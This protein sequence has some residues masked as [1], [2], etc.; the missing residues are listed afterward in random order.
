MFYL[1]NA[2]GVHFSAA[3][4]GVIKKN[5]RR[6]AEQDICL[7]EKHLQWQYVGWIQT[8]GN[9]WTSTDKERVEGYLQILQ[10]RAQLDKSGQ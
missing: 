4:K 7:P 5:K 1:V 6:K 3:I 10:H 8:M 9:V 2:Q